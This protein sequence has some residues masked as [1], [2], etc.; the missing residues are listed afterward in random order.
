M[1]LRNYISTMRILLLPNGVIRSTA[2][3]CWT[4]VWS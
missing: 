2:D 4:Q 1:Q 3:V